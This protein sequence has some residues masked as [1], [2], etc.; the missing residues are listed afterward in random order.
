MSMASPAPA[1]NASS[2]D[3]TPD[4]EITSP[5]P[6]PKLVATSK[7]AQQLVVVLTGRLRLPGGAGTDLTVEMPGEGTLTLTLLGEIPFSADRK[8]M[9]V[10]CTL[11]GAIFCICK[12][13][14]SVVGPLCGQS[15]DG[16]S[17]QHL[18]MYSRLG[19][20]TLAF[21]SRQVPLAEFEEFNCGKVATPD[22]GAFA[23]K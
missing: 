16:N 5:E 20:R 4:G 18:S 9:S 8:R 10:L 1:A 6:D 11:K 12:G 17:L 15:F 2:L 22:R 19:L 13:A 14:D 3:L 7:A 21:A 23:W